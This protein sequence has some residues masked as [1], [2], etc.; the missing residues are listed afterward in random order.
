M[1]ANVHYAFKFYLNIIFDQIIELS[2]FPKI[3]HPDIVL[4]M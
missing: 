3:Q 2:K 4:K 1:G